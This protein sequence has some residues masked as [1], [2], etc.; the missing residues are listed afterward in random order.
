MKL[1]NKINNKKILVNSK[2]A[3]PESWNWVDQ[4]IYGTLKNKVKVEQFGL[5]L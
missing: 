5:I 3:T 1:L 4:G 2:N